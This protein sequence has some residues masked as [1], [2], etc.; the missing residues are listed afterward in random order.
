VEPPGGAPA[1]YAAG[2]VVGALMGLFVALAASALIGAIGGVV[3]GNPHRSPSPE[4][5]IFGI[6]LLGLVFAVPGAILGA[7]VG[8][9]VVAMRR[10]N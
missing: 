9:F 3:P 1:S 7:C 6:F 2:G 5:A 8:L 10:R 4:A